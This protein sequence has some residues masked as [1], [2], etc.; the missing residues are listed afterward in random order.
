MLENPQLIP[1]GRKE[2]DAYELREGD[3]APEASPVDVLIP[4]EYRA[5]TYDDELIDEQGGQIAVC[6][7]EGCYHC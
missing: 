1:F 7:T 3:I 2:Y 4:R 5:D 6:D